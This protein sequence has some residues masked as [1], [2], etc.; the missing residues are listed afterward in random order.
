[1]YYVLFNPIQK[2]MTCYKTAEPEKYIRDI[3]KKCYP[4]SKD[5]RMNSVQFKTILE[6]GGVD[7]FYAVILNNKPEECQWC[8]RWFDYSDMPETIK[9]ANNHMDW[10][11]SLLI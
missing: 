7:K 10:K 2:I 11:L 6:N 1:M 9:W 8:C 5:R 3:R 4:G